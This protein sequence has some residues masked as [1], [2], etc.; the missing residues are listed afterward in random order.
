MK[1]NLIYSWTHLYAPWNLR[2]YLIL[3]IPHQKIIVPPPPPPEKKNQRFKINRLAIETYLSK[4]KPDNWYGLNKSYVKVLHVH[5]QH[6][7]LLPLG[8]YY[9]LSIFTLRRV[10][11]MLQVYIHFSPGLALR[12]HWIDVFIIIYV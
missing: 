6:S 4:E 10:T 3:Y 8:M 12:Q 1:E 5:R 9:T 7:R 11:G 2:K